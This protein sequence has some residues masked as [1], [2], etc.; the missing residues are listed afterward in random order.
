MPSRNELI[1]SSSTVDE[2]RE[3]LG[4]ESLEYL[5]MDDLRTCVDEPEDFCYACF[6]GRYPVTLSEDLDKS[7]FE[8]GAA[9]A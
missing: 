3:Y 9:A 4:V 5:G 6:D 2:I 1:A 7:V 8:K